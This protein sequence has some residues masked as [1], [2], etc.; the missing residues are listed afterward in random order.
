MRILPD[1]GIGQFVRV[2]DVFPC[3]LDLGQTGHVI[4]ARAV[5]KRRLEGHLCVLVDAVAAV[6]TLEVDDGFRSRFWEMTWMSVVNM[7]PTQAEWC[8]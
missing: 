6:T 8:G 2:N 1:W 3:E 5:H 4:V 7:R